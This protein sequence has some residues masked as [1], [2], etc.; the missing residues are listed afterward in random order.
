MKKEITNGKNAGVEA[1]SHGVP[2]ATQAVN[3]SRS[4]FFR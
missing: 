1:A 2:Q 3:L 4:P